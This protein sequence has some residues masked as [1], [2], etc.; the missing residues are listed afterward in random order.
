MNSLNIVQECPFC[1]SSSLAMS[2]AVLMPFVAYR[3]FGWTP[4]TIDSRW[5]LRDLR[6]G[7][8]YPLC[9]SVQCQDC[10]G[11][12]L[13]IRF[14]DEG[15]GR[16]YRE[17][18]GV[19]YTEDRE[20]FEPGYK[21]RN[22]IL[23]QQA[24]LLPKVEAMISAHIGTPASVLD[25]GGDT[26]LNTPFRSLCKQHH[27]FDISGKPV[28]GNAVSVDI[29]TI[30]K[31]RYELVTLCHVLE[32]VPFPHA[33]LRSI[34]ESIGEAFLYIEVPYEELIRMNPGRTDLHTEKHHWH[35]HINFFTKDALTSLVRDSGFTVVHSDVLTAPG[36]DKEH[37]VLSLLGTLA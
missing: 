18:R 15:M 7:M 1:R 10:G 32:H 17:Y 35:E 13:D 26:G 16:L 22:A 31:T 5:G 29:D 12:F 25:W 11:L 6:P 34:R 8:A 4:V 2:S 36:A 37:Y 23:M 19:V 27:I 30:R 21:A 9:N 14:D 20:R 3:V 33:L 28:T 24:P